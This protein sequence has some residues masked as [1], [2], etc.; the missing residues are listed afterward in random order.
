MPPRPK[1]VFSTHRKASTTLPMANA[2]TT[3]LEKRRPNSRSIRTPPSGSMGMSQCC[4]GRMSV[5]HRVEVVDIQGF[6]VL[7]NGQ[8]NRQAARGFG[9]RHHHHEEREQMSGHLLPLVGEGDEG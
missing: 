7:E 6:P 4:I 9:R 8:N 2:L 1:R 5:L 3:P